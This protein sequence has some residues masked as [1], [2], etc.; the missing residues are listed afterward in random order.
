MFCPKCGVKLDKSSRYCPSCGGKRKRSIL[1]VVLFMI[2]LSVSALV[3]IEVSKFLEEKQLAR[4]VQPVTTALQDEL[5]SKEVEEPIKV[6]KPADEN[7][8]RKLTEI[9]A[10]A[11][12]NVYT[13]HTPYGQGSG[14]LY[15]DKGIVVT[16]AHVV[17]GSTDVIVTTM[18]E[19]EHTGK[20]IGYSNEIDVAIIKVT[21]F[22]GRKPSQIEYK[23]KSLVGEEVIALGSPLGYQNTATMGY[24]T[25]IDRN[26]NIDNFIYSNLYQTSAPIA[27]GSSGGPLVSQKSEKIIAINSAKDTRDASIGFSIPIYTVHSLIESWIK[28]PMTEDQIYAQFYYSDGLFY[29]DYLWEYFDSGYFSDGYYSDDSSYYEYWDYHY[30]YYDWYDEYDD[31]YDHGYYEDY[32]GD[33]YYDDGY[34]E[35]YYGDDYY[36]DGYSDDF[37]EDYDEWENDFESSGYIDYEDDDLEIYNE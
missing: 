20:V 32:Y 37:F 19:T 1:L 30:D 17:E 18:R 25:G 13:I 7:K 12:Q 5:S 8:V 21:D 29:Y 14:F 36:D 33:D 6:E 22:V 26:F 15:N 23:N 24:I 10:D 3:F 28:Q 2:F 34:Y 4:E 11:Q 16:N 27:P 35:D 9:I 31:Y